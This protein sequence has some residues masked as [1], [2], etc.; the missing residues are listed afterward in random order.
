MKRTV[1]VNDFAE[2]LKKIE[3]KDV[4]FEQWKRVEID[5]KK[6][7]RVVKV[8]M[9]TDEFIPYITKEYDLFIQHTERIS[10]QYTALNDLKTNLPQGH[11]IVQM[12]FAEN[13]Q[14]QTMDEIQSAYWNATSITL[15]PVV[16]YYKDGENLIHKNIVFVSDLNHHNSTAVVA[17]LRNLIPMLQDAFFGLR[18]IHYW[19]DSPS[20]Q[21][22][23]RYIFNHIYNHFSLYGIFADWNYFEVGHGKGPCDGIGGTCKRAASEAVKQDKV[24]IQD[25][26]DFFNWA[27]KNEKAISYMFYSDEEYNSA[28]NYLA[29]TIS[30]AVPGTMSLHAVRTDGYGKMYVRQTSCYCVVCRRG[31]VCNGWT[32]HNLFVGVM[33][34]EASGVVEELPVGTDVIQS[35]QEVDIAENDYVAAIYQRKWYIGK[36]F[37]SDESDRTVEIS[38]MVQSKEFFKWPERSDVIWLD[39]N[40]VLCIIDAPTAT[41]KSSRMFKMNE[42]S[43]QEAE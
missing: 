18:Y 34:A 38:F 39:V 12:D 28:A 24:S 37:S 6:R 20:S 32:V 43:K 1:T 25:A 11:A 41:G 9:T 8:N 15:H 35:K 5:G 33:E 22:R 13:F 16:A 36:V 29:N 10:A 3:T 30:K 42:A 31:N 40:D 17:I 2:M 27:T 21:Y 4:E 14:C 7:M 26:R 23:N 19:T